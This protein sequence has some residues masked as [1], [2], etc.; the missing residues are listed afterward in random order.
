MIKLTEEQARLKKQVNDWCD[1]VQRIDKLLNHFEG[2]DWVFIVKKIAD[3]TLRKFP[4]IG[5]AS[6]NQDFDLVAINKMLKLAELL[7]GW[8][9]E[10]YEYVMWKLCLKK[11][12]TFEKSI[13][14][15]TEITKNC[16]KDEFEELENE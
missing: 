15:C 4:Y 11:S 16:L 5:T 13:K 10:W 7:E 14:Y 12:F 9:C 1:Q 8:G 6:H 2:R 3:K